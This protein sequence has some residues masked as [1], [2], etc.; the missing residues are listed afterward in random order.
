[1]VLFFLRKR[2]SPISVNETA[3]R[4]TTNLIL[5]KHAKCRMGCRYI[6]E[7]EIKEIISGG[8]LNRKKSGVGEKNDMTYAIE[9]YSDEKQHIRVVV[10]PEDDGLV[11]I[12]VID[13]D[14]DWPCHCD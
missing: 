6:D 4:D 9:G 11:I 10:A 7:R 2:N 3:Y 1:L 13:L 12:T 14:H 8:Q 5:T